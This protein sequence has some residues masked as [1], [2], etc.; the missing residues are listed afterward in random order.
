MFWPT[1]DK[2]FCPIDW[3]RR[4]KLKISFGKDSNNG[5]RLETDHMG[6]VFFELKWALEAGFDNNCG[7]QKC[8]EGWKILMGKQ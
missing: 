8:G 3:E 7:F 1:L 5:Q 2:G 6:K 4:R